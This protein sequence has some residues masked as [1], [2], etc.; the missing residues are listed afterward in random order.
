[1]S[2]SLGLALMLILR[3]GEGPYLGLP[4]IA[5]VERF[6]VPLLLVAALALVTAAT[7]AVSLAHFRPPRVGR[8]TAAVTGGL[9]R[10][11]L[12]SVLAGCG[13]IVVA[14]NQQALTTAYRHN[15]ASE[16][17]ELAKEGEWERAATDPRAT[18]AVVLAGNGPYF[19]HRRT[20]DI[21][22]KSDRH[23]ARLRVPGS[24]Y[25]RPGH[26][27]SDL[28]YSIHRLRPDL[29]DLGSSIFSPTHAMRFKRWGYEPLPNGMLV[30][31]DS[32]LVDRRRLK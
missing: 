32:R 26:N 24:G 10:R 30:R 23:I 25:F 21:L 20:I 17:A 16:D 1:M 12:V 22:G 11:G 5:H 7:L 3:F 9:R 4:S 31:T 15:Q 18:I 14:T 6:V 8:F 27:K 29:V 19:S 2:A 28:D 13:L